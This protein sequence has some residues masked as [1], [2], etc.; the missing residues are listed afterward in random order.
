MLAELAAGYKAEADLEK[1]LERLRNAGHGLSEETPKENAAAQVA[2]A[3]GVQVRRVFEAAGFGQV[4]DVALDEEWL[5]FAN[6]Q[7][8][9][10]FGQVDDAALDAEWLAFA[11]EQLAYAGTRIK[12]VEHIMQRSGPQI[13]DRV[14]SG[15]SPVSSGDTISRPNSPNVELEA[16]GVEIGRRWRS[17]PNPLMLEWSESP[18]A[19]IESSGIPG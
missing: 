1:G 2:T 14:T 16:L 3:A 11:N 5:A 15:T 10:G 18:I 9:A 4:D 19:A 13:S 12:S 6:E 8:A 17:L 7:L